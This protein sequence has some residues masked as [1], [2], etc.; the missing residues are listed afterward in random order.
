MIRNYFKI[1]WRSLRKN[2]GFT[3]INILGLAI[4][5]AAAMLIFLWI[6]SEVNFD[7]FYPNT[8]RLYAVGTREPLDNEISVFFS[9]P[10]PL[11]PVIKEEFPEVTNS[12]RVS[13]ING[14]LFTVDSKKLT[15]GDAAFVDSTFLEMF[16]LPLLSGDPKTAL[17]DPSSIVL[18]EDLARKLY[19]TTDVIGKN[20]ALD[21]NEI[22]TVSGVI[23]PIPS[24]SRF[25]TWEYLLPWTCMEKLGYADESWGN[26]SV[27]AFVELKPQAD[28]PAVQRKMQKIL[29]RHSADLRSETFLQP[30]SEK[31][32]Y[33]KF[34]NG[35]A[36]G[37]RVEMVRVF[38]II[39][40]FILLIA[41]IN[42]MNL[43]TAQSEKRAKEV[44]VRKVI[45]AQKR[46]LIAQFLTESLLLTTL[47]GIF[48][49][50][51]SLLALP[52]FSQ[53]VGRELFIDFTS[54]KFWSLFGAFILFTGLLAGSYPAFFLSS[55][56]PIK[57][58]KG[59]FQQVQ[60]KISARKILVVFQFVI[61]IILIISTLVIQQQIQHGQ[62]RESGYQKDNLVYIPEKGDI[63]K[64]IQLIKQA[65]MEQQI[66]A[67][68]TRTMSPLT[69]RWSGWNGFSWEGK[70]PKS[71][72]Q[73]NRQTADDKLV[74]TAGFTLV[75]GR[76]FD[77]NKFPTDSNAAILNESAI[78]VMGLKDP[79]GNYIMDGGSKFHIIGVIKDFIQESPFDPVLPLVFE[80][81]N[82]FG[83]QTI[84]IKFNLNLTTKEALE[85]T[86]QVFKTFNPD[87]PFEYKFIDD[88]YADKFA[89]SQKIGK[90]ASLFSGLTIFIS[91]LGLLG[92]AA[93]MAENRTKEI[94]I[95]KVLGASI[96][97]ISK[98]LS[99]E[100]LSLVLFA[101]LVAFPIAFWAMSNYL[102]SFAYRTAIGW[103]IF[104]LAGLGALFISAI[105]VSYQSIKAARA[106]PVDSLRNE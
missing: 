30:L 11:A 94:G 32:L 28:L 79:V 80:G 36:V 42:F 77:L 68:I 88:E 51:L 38:T 73:F 61:A 29:Q 63:S 6:S 85:R 13:R 72:I 75:E 106:N 9:T 18:S 44:G 96:F 40:G 55:F 91:C 100:F 64:N 21:R 67:S 84:H 93:F 1:A 12:T 33:S 39:A 41:C 102:K 35:K 16:G 31:Y 23:K 99:N 90:L 62:D 20:L 50:V 98:L 15:T 70:D 4:G 66:A 74:Q 2:K 54:W 95:R 27:L 89:E 45:G 53:L 92:L 52:A 81:A 71:I 43:S 78:Q 87:Y 10:K 104:M 101:C 7:R 48:A 82:G 49:I 19:G 59:R 86:E 37:G 24:N 60:G 14:F 34:E 5:M 3:A 25:A 22:L 57:V 97:S 17:T 58:L 105:T 69:E 83:M 65:L 56:R 76:D 103:D 47:A 46:T 8:D 26:S